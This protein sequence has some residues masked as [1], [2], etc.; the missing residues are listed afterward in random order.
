MI[1]QGKKKLSKDVKGLPA[2]LE[3]I[4]ATIVP[5]VNLTYFS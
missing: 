5:G 3:W 4:N 1:I 2:L